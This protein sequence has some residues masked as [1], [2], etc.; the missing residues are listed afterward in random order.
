MKGRTIVGLDDA[1]RVVDSKVFHAGTAIRDGKV[2]TAGGR[3][4]GATAVGDNF[5]AAKERA[6]E[7][8]HKIQF[9]GVWSRSD[10]ADRAIGAVSGKR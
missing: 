8:V 1:A 10:I 9:P 6:Y 3:V 4:L 2:V 7:C 5:R